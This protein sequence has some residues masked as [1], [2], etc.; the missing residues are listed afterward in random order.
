MKDQ[1]KIEPCILRVVTRF[2][3]RQIHGWRMSWHII[4]ITL[5]SRCI[6]VAIDTSLRSYHRG[7]RMCEI[8]WNR[9]SIVRRN[10][11]ALGNTDEYF[12]SSMLSSLFN[13]PFLNRSRDKRTISFITTYQTSFNC[14]C[15]DLST[16]LIDHSSIILSMSLLVNHNVI[17]SFLLQ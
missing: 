17:S 6:T 3:S 15:F 13:Y 10:L 7:E 9:S 11:F 12:R 14:H 2:Y 16:S 4:Y 8:V 5:G 1:T